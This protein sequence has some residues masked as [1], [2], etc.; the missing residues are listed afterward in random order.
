MRISMLTANTEQTKRFKKREKLRVCIKHLQSQL[1][2]RHPNPPAVYALRFRPNRRSTRLVINLASLKS[3]CQHRRGLQRQLPQ[4]KCYSNLLA[5]EVKARCSTEPARMWFMVC[6]LFSVKIGCLAF[7]VRIYRHHSS[8]N[9]H[10]EITVARCN[11]RGKK[12][13]LKTVSRLQLIQRQHETAYW[14][15][16]RFFHPL[17]WVVV[18]GCRL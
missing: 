17:F 6:G 18:Q 9:C 11:R 10:S 15:R 14:R 2:Q 13:P 1:H 7:P 8:H 16:S 3:T 4:A 12:G 5:F